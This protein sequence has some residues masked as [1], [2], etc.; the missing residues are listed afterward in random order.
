[1]IHEREGLPV[2]SVFISA[3]EQSGDLHASDLIKELRKS[4]TGY[5]LKISGLGGDMMKKERADLLFHISE[6]SA[7]GFTEVLK[8]YGY[9]KGVLHSCLEHVK[10]AGPD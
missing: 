10:I 4:L 8:K 9:F 6:L 3:G 2:K 1:M 5:E 7:I